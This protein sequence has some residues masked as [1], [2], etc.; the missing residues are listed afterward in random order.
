MVSVQHNILSSTTVLNTEQG[1]KEVEHFQT[2]L[3]I[4]EISQKKF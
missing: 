3:Q 1:C 4:K 2:F